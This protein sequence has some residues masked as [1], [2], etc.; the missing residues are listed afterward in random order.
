MG[1]DYYLADP[2]YMTPQEIERAHHFDYG[3]VICNKRLDG[4][5]SDGRIKLV[6]TLEVP[7]IIFFNLP[8]DVLLVNSNNDLQVRTISDLIAQIRRNQ[9]RVITVDMAAEM[10]KESH[11]QWLRSRPNTDAWNSFLSQYDFVETP[12]AMQYLKRV[13]QRDRHTTK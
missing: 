13:Y 12:T 4:G 10:T 6:Y 5:D 1:T 3:A 9:G 11:E 8:P 7:N 2:M